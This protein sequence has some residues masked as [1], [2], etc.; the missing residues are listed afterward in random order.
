MK[1]SALKLR[2]NRI[3]DGG[4]Q[5]LFA[6]TP[7]SNSANLTLINHILCIPCSCFEHICSFCFWNWNP[8]SMQEFSILF[9]AFET[10][11]LGWMPTI[12]EVFKWS[13]GYCLLDFKWQLKLKRNFPGAIFVLT[14]QMFDEVSRRR[15]ESLWQNYPQPYI[16][17]RI[18]RWVGWIRP[19]CQTYMQNIHSVKKYF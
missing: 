14:E 15:K 13:R 16:G 5:E 10:Y 18:Y 2:N 9:K 7:Y 17:I 8:Y 12:N 19:K 11:A 6:S 4:L 3:L 1:P